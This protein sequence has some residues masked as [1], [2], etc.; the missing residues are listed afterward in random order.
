M[1]K[2]NEYIIE[3]QNFSKS[4]KKSMAVDDIS[5]AV[6]RGSFHGFL[7]ANGAGKTTTIK[8]MIG[9]YGVFKGQIFIEGMLSKTKEAKESIGY[10]P[11]RPIFPVSQN[12]LTYL[13]YMGN[14]SGLDLKDS[15]ARAEEL[16]IKYN[17]ENLAKKN[18]NKLSSGQKKKILLIQALI[19]KPS[20]IIMDEPASNLDPIA[21]AE[22]FNDLRELNKEGVTIFITSHILAELDGYIDH[23][24]VLSKGKIIYN[25]NVNSLKGNKTL[26]NA[27][28]DIIKK[29]DIE[30]EVSN[31]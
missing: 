18:P 11:E 8:A 14:L 24:T 1:S 5:F 21:R 15:K 22:L 10:V 12:V 30:N 28:L 16:L 7:G 27:F 29:S 20:L 9:A 13:T 3:V 26:V 19:N 25:G 2:T 31:V 23:A 6:K 17:I 4:F